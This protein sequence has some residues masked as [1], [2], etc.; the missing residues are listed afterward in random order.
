MRLHVFG[1]GA[2]MLLKEG[3]VWRI[4]GLFAG[5]LFLV[6]CTSTV[7]ETRGPLPKGHLRGSRTLV[8]ADVA[9]PYRAATEDAIV[10]RIPGAVAASGVPVAPTSDALSSVN[11]ADFDTV[12]LVRLA[13]LTVA[14]WPADP[15]PDRSPPISKTIGGL[16]LDVSVR[17]V[18]DW[19][20]VWGLRVRLEGNL[21]GV[22]YVQPIDE[23]RTAA[24][25]ALAPEAAEHAARRLGKA[26]IFD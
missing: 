17:R 16:D 7:L 5:A 20:E 12:V 23:A 25:S 2:K 21:P 9:E 15:L 26:R 22:E 6:G 19:T 14:Y 18:A 11:P 10:R 1:L 3:A 4:P 24:V 13:K 8:V